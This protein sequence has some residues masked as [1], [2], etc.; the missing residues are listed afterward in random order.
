MYKFTSKI[1]FFFH[2]LPVK[3]ERML[4]Y[5]Q[6]IHQKSIG[7]NHGKIAFRLDKINR[8]LNVNSQAMVL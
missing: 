5:S 4:R 7:T 8:E 1:L 2:V 6:G 3:G